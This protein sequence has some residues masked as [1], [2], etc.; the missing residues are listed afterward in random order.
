MQN[1]LS[2]FEGFKGDIE[3]FVFQNQ[4][5]FHS[6]T[7]AFG[8]IGDMRNILQMINKKKFNNKKN[9]MKESL[10]LETQ[11]NRFLDYVKERLSQ[12]DVKLIAEF[13]EYNE[14]GLAYET[15]CTQTYEY[16]IRISFEF[17]EILYFVAKSMEIQVY[18]WMQ[19]LIIE[20]V[21]ETNWDEL[22]PIVNVLNEVSQGLYI[23]DIE[24]E[25]GFK[26]E[27]ILLLMH[28]IKSYQ[29]KESELKNPFFIS[30]NIDEKNI[31]KNCFQVVLKEIEEW[32]FSAR[33]GISINEAK[34]IVDK[35][36]G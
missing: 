11:L 2:C 6:K 28:R 7:M 29:V 5:G 34:K 13:I 33:I 9:K 27:Q 32:E 22:W 25:V 31:I 3:R 35:I 10:F 18:T 26:C 21:L 20:N 15:L 16:D 8:S 23:D 17:Y 24:Q 4:K 14:C 19:E 12:D 36:T 30:F 1:V